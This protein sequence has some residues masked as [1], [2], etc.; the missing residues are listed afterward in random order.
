MNA[1]KRMLIAAAVMLAL[2][3]P[4]LKAA[5]QL[6]IGAIL[7]DVRHEWFVEVIEGMKKAGEDLG[8]K[9]S[10]QSSDSDVAKESD[11]IDNFIAQQYDAITISPQNDEASIPA[12]ERAIAAGIPVV[13]WNS[14]VATDQVKHFVGVDNYNLGRDTGLYAAKYINEKMGGKAKVAI[15]GNTLYSV[16]RDRV[17]GFMDEMAKLPGVEIVANQDAEFKETGM[18]VTESVLEAHPDTQ[19]VWCWNQGALLGALAAL[20]GKGNTDVVL[21]GTDMSIDLARAMLEPGAFLHAVTT[22]QP[23]E[24][25]YQAV[26]AA[27]ELAQKKDVP[28]EILAPLKTYVLS[29]KA[30]IQKYL[31]DRKYLQ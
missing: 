1:A 16:G 7:L 4:G 3:T 8:V 27:V 20:N 23:Y 6:E 24:L 5:D 10:I 19:I 15:V 9:V 17:R 26:K 28:A 21:M 25:G 11:T 31:D 22:Q 12:V 29:D 2:V 13:P 14:K 18:A 30:D